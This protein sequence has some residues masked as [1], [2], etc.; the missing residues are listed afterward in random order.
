[1]TATR[2]PLLRRAARAVKKLVTNA[3]ASP[4]RPRASADRKTW[5]DYPRFPPF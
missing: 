2:I 5:V 1:M 4:V 3:L